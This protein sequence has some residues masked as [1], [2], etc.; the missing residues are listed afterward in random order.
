M[1]T[2]SRLQLAHAADWAEQCEHDVITTR[3]CWLYSTSLF[4]CV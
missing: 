4:Y 1:K 3:C 2:H